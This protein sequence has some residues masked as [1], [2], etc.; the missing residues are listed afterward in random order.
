MDTGVDSL[1]HKIVAAYNRLHFAHATFLPA[2]SICR[3]TPDR[4]LLVAVAGR[5]GSGKSTLAYPLADRVNELILGRPVAHP[6]AIDGETAVAAPNAALGTGDEVAI[7]VGQDGWHYTRQ[8]LDEFPDP[9]LAHWRRGAAFTFDLPAYSAFIDA[10]RIPLLPTP[11]PAIPFPTFDHKLKDPRLSP[12][13]VTAH[14]RIVI[15]E[16]LYTL[17]SEPGWCECAAQMDMRVWVEVPRDVVLRRVLKR[18]M[19]AG[20]VTD[21]ETARL[22]VDQSD[23]ANGDDV[24]AYRYLPTDTIYPEDHPQY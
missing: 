19:Q 8:Q 16:G 23:M 10:L 13:P 4:R 22:R 11:P 3:L 12:V 2:L 1:A 17:L 20:I 21:P 7:C 5:P 24:Y 6:A 15:V 18:N 14:H 9:K